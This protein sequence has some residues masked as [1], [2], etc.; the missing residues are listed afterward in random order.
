MTNRA[1]D[2][3][4]DAGTGPAETGRNCTRWGHYAARKRTIHYRMGIHKGDGIHSVLVRPRVPGTLMSHATPGTGWVGG[5][6]DT[7]PC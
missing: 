4:N 3:E 5:I 2:A 7:R 1:I 6:R